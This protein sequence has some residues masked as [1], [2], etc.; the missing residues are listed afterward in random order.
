MKKH[1]ERESFNE[2]HLAWLFLVETLLKNRKICFQL[3]IHI[4]F[5]KFLFG[6]STGL[7]DKS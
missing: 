5:C 3:W 2:K 7:I 4:F 6:F 1:L